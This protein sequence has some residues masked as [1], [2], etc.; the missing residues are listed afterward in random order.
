MRGPFEK[1]LKIFEKDWE[2]FKGVL[3]LPH[4]DWFSIELEG[5]SEAE[6]CIVLLLWLLK[7]GKDKLHLIE[8]VQVLI[9]IVNV[10]LKDAFP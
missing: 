10:C 4:V 9:R 6:W 5:L 8:D 7:V 1:I 2:E 3:L